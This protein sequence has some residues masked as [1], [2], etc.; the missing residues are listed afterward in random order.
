MRAWSSSPS[1]SRGLPA[2]PLMVSPTP[3]GPAAPASSTGS[4]DQPDR[5]GDV[6]AGRWAGQRR[7]YRVR[8]DGLFPVPTSG[9]PSPTPARSANTLGNRGF[10]RCTGRRILRHRTFCVRRRSTLRC[11]GGIAKVREQRQI[12][13]RV[14]YTQ[15]GRRVGRRI[16]DQQQSPARDRLGEHVGTALAEQRMLRQSLA[17]IQNC[18]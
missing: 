2:R 16:I 13:R 1:G 18:R 15:N 14:Q 7:A 9:R 3:V 4:M 11:V 5:G 6:F 17:R 12:L 8:R 10:P